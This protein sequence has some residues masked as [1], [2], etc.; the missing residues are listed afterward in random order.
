MIKTAEEIKADFRNM[1]KGSDLANRITGGVYPEGSRPRDSVKEDAVVILTAALSGEIQ[2]GVITVHIYV[3]NK[4]Y[5]R[6]YLEKNWERVVEIE[7]LARTWVES[8][9]AG[10]SCYRIKLQQTISSQGDENTQQHYVVVC[11]SYEYYE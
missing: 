7:S 11:L 2:S 1:L 6:G 4:D 5:G 3:P 10:K 9:T 8:L